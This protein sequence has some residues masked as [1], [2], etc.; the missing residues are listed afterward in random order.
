MDDF[1]INDD[2]FDYDD[3]V[4]ISNNLTK[5]LSFRN[6]DLYFIIDSE[7]VSEIITN[8]SITPLPKVPEYI[9]GIINLRGQIAPIVD[10]RIKMGMKAAKNT[11]IACI[12]VVKVE[13]ILFGILVDEVSHVL[14]IDT[15]MITSYSTTKDELV[16]GIIR[17]EEVVYLVFD[18]NKLISSIGVSLIG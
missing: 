1:I 10:L 3:Q 15:D 11:E 8:T 17:A 18:A 5:Y 14:D 9:S 7:F 4:E 16:S 6:D 12:I 13:S 2:L